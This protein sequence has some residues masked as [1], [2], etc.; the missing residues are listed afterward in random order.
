MQK[1]PFIYKREKVVG[2]RCAELQKG[3]GMKLLN[4]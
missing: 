4:I 2:K 3:I 1:Y